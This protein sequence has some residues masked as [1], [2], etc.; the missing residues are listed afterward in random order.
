MRLLILG[1]DGATFDVIDKFNKH[2]LPYLK[3]LIANG[4]RGSLESTFPPVSA[5]AWIACATGKNPGKTG[6]FDFLNRVNS[7]S[8][9]MKPLSSEEFKRAISFWDYLSSHDIRSGIWN[10]PGLYPPYSINGLMV[11]GLGASPND[12][13]TYPRELKGE[14]FQVCGEYTIHVPYTLPRYK[15]NPSLFVSDIMKLLNQNEKA[16]NFLLKQNLDVFMG[17]ISATDFAQ[18]YMWKFLDRT[19]PLYNEREAKKYS[20]D[21]LQIWQRIDNLLEN[22]LTKLSSEPNILIVS[23]HGFGPHKQ[24][25]YINSWLESEGYLVR[26]KGGTRSIITLQS[27]AL[28][29]IDRLAKFSPQLVTALKNKGSK[30]AR[31]FLQQIDM[32]KTKAFASTHATN[33]GQIYINSSPESPIENEQERELIKR[34]IATKLQEVCNK[35]NLKANVYFAEDIYSGQFVHLAPDILFEINDFECSVHYQFSNLQQFCTCLVCRCQMIWT[36]GYLQKFLRKTVS[37]QG[38]KSNIRRLTEEKGK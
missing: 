34:E 18:H 11:S 21:F 26:K 22:T 15:D 3:N 27:L 2:E 1:L 5:P 7:N 8:Y 10:Y 29:T 17:V 13:I 20:S 6:T 16:L 24:S 19:H 4:V 9:K 12:E 23:D 32:Q 14:L 35:L 30:Y 33:S 25:F 37:Q 28:K 36:G 38:E 31:P